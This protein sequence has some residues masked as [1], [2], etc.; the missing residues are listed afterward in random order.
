MLLPTSPQD[1][2]NSSLNKRP[3]LECIDGAESSSITCGGTAP[4]HL[5]KI[6][7]ATSIHTDSIAERETACTETLPWS[8]SDDCHS[9]AGDSAD[10]VSVVD[11]SLSED[12]EIAAE[13]VLELMSCELEQYDNSDTE[14]FNNT[15]CDVREASAHRE[16]T[17]E[18]FESLPEI[19]AKELMS[20]LPCK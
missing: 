3:S 13:V 10:S 15:S 12:D 9:Q 18:I 16:S 1:Q 5:L 7:P 20:E 11:S 2:Q 6:V 17:A 14:I 19:L 4:I 8:I